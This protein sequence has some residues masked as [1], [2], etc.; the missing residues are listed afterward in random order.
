MSQPTHTP[1]PKAV[2]VV[3]HPRRP[4]TLPVAQAIT[5][6]LHQRGVITHLS[7]AWDGDSH[8]RL[9]QKEMVIAIGGDGAMLRAVRK[10]A[11]YRIPVLGINMGY[12]GFLPE[13]NPPHDWEQALT[14]IFAGDYWVEKRMTIHVTVTRGDHV[15][16]AGP[17]LND[18]VI[19]RNGPTGTVLLQTF[20]DNYWTT[21]YHADAL[22]IATP[23][24]STAYALGAGGPI[25]PPELRNILIV[26]VAPHLSMDRAIVLSEGATVQVVVSPER[27]NDTVVISDGM[28][29]GAVQ[30]N[31]VIAV[32]AGE[33][34]GLF[35]RMRE[36]NYFYRSLLDRLEPR[37]PNRPTPDHLHLQF[38]ER[39]V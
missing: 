5:D 19:T 15:I 4:E 27:D 20:I 3:A 8:E 1:I 10:C 32:R 39:D 16:A 25:L 37:V 23:T 12:L 34:H 29:I 31:D 26:P 38:T 22:I 30:A 14:R 28:E 35:V 9:P 18:I 2:E 17:A 36:R 24:G 7:E 6:W 21:T 11:P 33:D 13:V